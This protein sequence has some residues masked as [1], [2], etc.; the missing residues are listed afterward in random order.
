MHYALLP[1]AWFWMTKRAHKICAV[2]E[3]ALNS[4]LFPSQLLKAVC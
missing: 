3:E 4:L 1:E 2:K